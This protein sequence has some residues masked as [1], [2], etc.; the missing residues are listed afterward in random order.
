MEAGLGWN[1]HEIVRCWNEKWINIPKKKKKVF[2]FRLPRSFSLSYIHSFLPF[3][4][5]KWNP[6]RYFF[7]F[8]FQWDGI[9]VYFWSHHLHRIR[10]IRI[11]EM[12]NWNRKIQK[13]CQKL[14]LQKFFFYLSVSFFYLWGLFKS[15]ATTGKKVS[16]FFGCHNL[17]Q[18]SFRNDKNV[19]MMLNSCKKVFLSFSVIIRLSRSRMGKH[20][21]SFLFEIRTFI[22]AA[23]FPSS[24]ALFFSQ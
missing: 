8:S 16:C 3:L 11:S 12:K 17:H 24:R 15:P 7:P 6:K 13:R 21:K 23:L 22:I 2:S 1:K 10:S 9:K 5:E 14:W 18:M 4:L 20:T 19:S